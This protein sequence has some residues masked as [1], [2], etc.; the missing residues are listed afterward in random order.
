MTELSASAGPLLD[1]TDLKVHFPIR[2]GLL[3]RPTGDVR[4]VDGVTFTIAQAETL[5]LV[6]ESGCGKST[7]GYAVLGMISPTGGRIEFGGAELTRQ[8]RAALRR[9]QRDMQI[10]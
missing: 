9:A 4:A 10:I 8:D 5:A 2:A 1:V 7:T 6:G 3:R